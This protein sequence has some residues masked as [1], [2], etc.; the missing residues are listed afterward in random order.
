MDYENINQFIKKIPE[1]N[2]ISSSNMIKYFV[3]YCEQNNINSVPKI[4]ED[5]FIQLR[6]KPYSNVASYL[7]QKSKGKTPLFFKNKDGSYSLLRNEYL[8]IEEELECFHEENA[9]NNLVDLSVFNAAPYYIQSNAKQMALCYDNNLY[10]A[11]LVLMRKLFE[12]LIIECF[13]RYN[14]EQEIKDVN[15]TFFYFSDLIDR[16]INSSKWNVSRNLITAIKK[17]KRYGDLSAH[18][19]RFLAKKTDIDDFRF[20]LRQCA[21]EIILTI[22]Y[23]N[24]T[25]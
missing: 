17:V 8:N 10:D 12:T 5:I 6:L 23:A 24:W 13:E 18:N 9:T 20:E 22:D 1:F 25:R 15:G 14:Y 21:E 16:F 7:S 2:G 19:R 11:T 3:F 4:I